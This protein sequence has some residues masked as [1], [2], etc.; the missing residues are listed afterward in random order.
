[1]WQHACAGR[2][3]WGMTLQRQHT[4]TFGRVGVAKGLTARRCRGILLVRKSPLENWPT[5]T[6]L[7]ALYDRRLPACCPQHG[8][9]CR[10]CQSHRPP[11]VAADG[12]WLCN[13]RNILL[14][15][16]RT[17]LRRSC[18]SPQHFSSGGDGH[19]RSAGGRATLSTRL[20]PVARRAMASHRPP[21]PP[22]DHAPLAV[23]P[24]PK[25]HSSS[26]AVWSAVWPSDARTATG[27]TPDWAYAL[28]RNGRLGR[29]TA[30]TPL[31]G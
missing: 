4:G 18:A 30:H 27:P 25:A 22:V 31:L 16:E 13:V 9:G 5:L 24:T 7:V 12:A 11:D 1:M 26:P 29:C 6:R 2:A 8:L 19:R 17:P 15:L 23:A 20:G 21:R 14:I 28:M 3:T 10:A